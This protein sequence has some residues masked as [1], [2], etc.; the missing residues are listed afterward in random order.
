M[1]RLERMRSLVQER[2]CGQ[3]RVKP[4]PTSKLKGSTPGTICLPSYLPE[5]IVICTVKF[6]Y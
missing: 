2:L 5:I 3:A 1:P 6:L 4:T